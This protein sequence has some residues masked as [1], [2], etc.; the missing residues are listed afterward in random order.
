MASDDVDL[1]RELK[2]GIAELLA[3]YELLETEKAQL[4]ESILE[5]NRQ[6]EILEKDK[7]ELEKKYENLKLARYLEFGYEDNQVAR[8]KVDNLLREIDKCIALLNK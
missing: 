2:A 7:S 6:M 1:I 4:K 8:K 3:R 5:L